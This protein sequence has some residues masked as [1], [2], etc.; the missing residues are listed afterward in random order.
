VSATARKSPPARPTVRWALGNALFA[1]AAWV[2]VG[3]KDSGIAYYVAVAFTVRLGI[4]GGWGWARSKG[5]PEWTANEAY[6]A[7]LRR[8]WRSRHTTA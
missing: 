4:D 3:L 5:V 8:W 7:R 6:I 2:I 1:V